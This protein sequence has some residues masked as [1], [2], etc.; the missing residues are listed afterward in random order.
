MDF[1]SKFFDSNAFRIHYQIGGEG[2]P[3]LLLHGYGE[4]G[5]IWKSALD[6]F[7]GHQ[8]ILPDFPG[9]GKSEVIESYSLKEMME[10]YLEILEFEKV[11]HFY[12]FGHSMG[13]YTSSEFVSAVPERLLGVGM[14]HTHP[15]GDTDEIKIN[16]KKRE[17]HIKNYGKDGFLKEFYP[18]LFGTRFAINFPEVVNEMLDYGMTLEP[19]SFIAGMRAMRLRPDHSSAFERFKNPVLFVVGDDDRAVPYDL[20]L[21]QL[22]LPAIADVHILQEIGHMSM[23]EDKATFSRI[24]KQFLHFSNEMASLI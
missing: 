4:D 11:N 10:V 19:H 22:S 7:E 8:L 18:I 23:L 12:L 20:S 24:V 3:I 9:F 5:N 21:K 2:P 13:G 14:I 17:D 16:R 6:A 15:F 1:T